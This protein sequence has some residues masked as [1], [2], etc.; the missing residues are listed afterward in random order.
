MCVYILHTCYRSNTLLTSRAGV[1]ERRCLY[2]DG[3]DG[4]VHTSST[5]EMHR[6]K[7]EM[8][9]MYVTVQTRCSN[10]TPMRRGGEDC[11][12]RNPTLSAVQAESRFWAGRRNWGL[13]GAII[14]WLEPRKQQGLAQDQPHPF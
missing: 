8:W 7:W 3:E 6:K 13:H 5:R 2:P 1:G 4:W 10:S 11:L 14:C 12:E 9:D